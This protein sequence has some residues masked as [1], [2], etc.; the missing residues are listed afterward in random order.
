VDA[1]ASVIPL[2]SSPTPSRGGDRRVPALTGDARVDL[3]WPTPV[4]SVDLLQQMRA[5][6][7]EM[8]AAIS[9]R[10]EALVAHMPPS[11]TPIAANELFHDQHRPQLQEHL[12][13]FKRCA[14]EHA[15]GSASAARE[16]EERVAALSIWPRLLNSTGFRDLFAGGVGLVWRHVQAYA[17]ELGIGYRRAELASPSSALE[18]VR[19]STWATYHQRGVQHEEHGH[20]GSQLSGVYYVRSPGADETAA[21]GGLLRVFDPRHEALQFMYEANQASPP[22]RASCTF[23][24]RPGL[25]L[26]WPSYLRHEVTPTNGESARISLPFDLTVQAHAQPGD[27][28][29][30][31]LETHA[32]TTSRG[33]E[34]SVEIE[35][36]WS[37][38]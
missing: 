25:L 15:S 30:G 37:D 17:D 27:T 3:L 21:G 22:P 9:E 13:A 4:Y 5:S 19:W 36:W 8:E 18:V 33:D 6:H 35:A 31:I 10:W 20:R 29:G 38:L 28:S 34:R 14:L 23:E 26:L 24:P 16:C 2:S 1:R 32:A 7:D 12:Q 11:T